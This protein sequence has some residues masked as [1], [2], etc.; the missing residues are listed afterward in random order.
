VIA[1]NA[2]LTPPASRSRKENVNPSPSSPIASRP[3]VSP[4]RPAPRRAVLFSTKN[5]HFGHTPPGPPRRL[6]SSAH[7]SIPI[8]S[9]LKRPSLLLPAAS[10]HSS[11]S[12]SS[13]DSMDQAAPTE[14]L[15]RHTTP[16][17]EDNPLQHKTLLVSPLRVLLASLDPAPDVTVTLKDIIEAWTVIFMRLRSR[18]PNDMDEPEALK[19]F[20]SNLE[21]ILTALERDIRRALVNPV[22]KTAIVASSSDEDGDAKSTLEEDDDT[23][24][25]PVK[26]IRGGLTEFEVTYARDLYMVCSAALKVVSLVFWVPQ[27]YSMIEGECTV[28]SV[29]PCRH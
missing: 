8:R 18:F 24:L 4:F 29:K 13:S 6:P 27:L 25:K 2:P 3:C 17:P 12:D 9:I 14:R 22:Q 20:Q 16:E 26:S 15:P 19:P 7:I 11:A 10:I 1:M 21:P 23:S 5:S 28:N